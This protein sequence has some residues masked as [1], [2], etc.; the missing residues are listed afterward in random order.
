MLDEPSFAANAERL[1]AAI[2]A[3]TAPDRAAEE[4]EKLALCNGAATGSDPS[5]RPSGAL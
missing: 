2:A 1:A 4:L 5:R 3:E